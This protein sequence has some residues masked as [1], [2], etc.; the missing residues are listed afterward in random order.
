[1]CF[2]SED[3]TWFQIMR[4]AREAFE[5]AGH[6]VAKAPSTKRLRFVVDGN[7]L[8]TPDQLVVEASERF[9]LN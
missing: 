3:K 5:A 2:F 6:S 7:R 1:M 4:E 9:G 8:M